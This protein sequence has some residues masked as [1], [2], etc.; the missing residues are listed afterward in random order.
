[1]SSLPAEFFQSLEQEGQYHNH[2]LEEED[3]TYLRASSV[4][5]LVVRLPVRVTMPELSQ[6]R[7]RMQEAELHE[8]AL[9]RG[10]RKRKN[11]KQYKH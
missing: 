6:G 8:V 7:W 9:G 2:R 5:R 10:H 11:P 4:Q 3:Y 1:M